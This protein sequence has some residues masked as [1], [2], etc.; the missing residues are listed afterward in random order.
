MTQQKHHQAEPPCSA[1]AKK[2][3][4][5][6]YGD[7]AP[8]ERTALQTH[9]ATCRACAATLA[10]YHAMDAAILALP[11]VMPLAEMPVAGL[12]HGGARF[13]APVNA[14]N[15]EGE[16]NFGGERNEVRP[17]MPQRHQ[18][19]LRPRLAFMFSTVMAVLVVG[20]LIA[21]FALLKENY[22][23]GTAKR[24]TH[25]ITNIAPTNRPHR[26]I[27][28]CIQNGIARS[29]VMPPLPLRQGV[30]DTLVYVDNDVPNTG[31]NKAA[32]PYFGVLERYDVVT[33]TT[34][35]ITRSANAVITQAELSSD[36]QWVMFVSDDPAAAQTEL[37]LVRVDGQDLQTLFCFSQ[38]GGYMDWSPDQKYVLFT[39]GPDS[40]FPAANS[41]MYLLNL[42]SG[43]LTTV[44]FSAQN[45]TY[46]P[47]GWVDATHIYFERSISTQSPSEF[48][49]SLYSLDITKI[50]ATKAD[51]HFIAG[52]LPEPV[53]ISSSADGKELY[54][55]QC[56]GSLKAAIPPCTIS[57]MPALG[58]TARIISRSQLAITSIQTFSPNGLF[59]IV[60]MNHVTGSTSTNGLWKMKSDGTGFVQ[61]IRTTNPLFLN[62]FSPHSWSNVSR[63]GAWYAVK[64]ETNSD[65]LA[66]GSMHGGPLTTINTRAE[67]DWSDSGAVGWTSF[68]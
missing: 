50:T 20:A 68:S 44:A 5:V 40:T 67:A 1:W 35:M 49:T 22:R 24:T 41:T 66:I 32:V 46:S 30:H 36:G 34:T 16:R 14:L 62:M 37:Q 64:I 2:L 17:A 4:I 59:L 58:G 38:V 61:L 25:T 3:A 18:N 33:H 65:I 63:D 23:S 19:E 7:L 60:N 28:S 12:R 21:G 54:I 56:G 45:Y 48:L 39:V 10:D 57:V 27:T 53:G 6:H 52:P 43:S 8:A 13:A 55:G 51:L 15:M 11:A 9:V 31:P 29:A 47:A 42:A 26:I